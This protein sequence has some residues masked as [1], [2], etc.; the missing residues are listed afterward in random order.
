[1]KATFCWFWNYIQVRWAPLVHS[2]ASSVGSIQKEGKL[3]TAV[4]FSCI[5]IESTAVSKWNRGVNFLKPMWFQNESD[6]S[7]FSCYMATKIRPDGATCVFLS[8]WCLFMSFK[9][10]SYCSMTLILLSIAYSCLHT[11]LSLD[12]SLRFLGISRIPPKGS[13][14]LIK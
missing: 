1:M 8:T 9:F 14:D 5:E 4:F 7:T 6:E 12:L 3:G 2:G 10:Y 11:L 13:C